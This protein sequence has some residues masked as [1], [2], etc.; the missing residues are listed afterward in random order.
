MT[1]RWTRDCS[2]VHSGRVTRVATPE[3]IP[4]SVLQK[5]ADYTRRIEAETCPSVVD[6]L[7]VMRSHLSVQYPLLEQFGSL[8]DVCR[9]HLERYPHTPPPF[10]G[11][12]A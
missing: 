9:S 4:F 5:Y 6:M 8:Q 10:L 2:K 11:P 1:L 12:V 7:T 3:V